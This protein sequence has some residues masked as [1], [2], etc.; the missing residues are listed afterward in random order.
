MM[1]RE[2]VTARIK[3]KGLISV[4]RLRGSKEAA[5]IVEA[6][7]AGGVDCVELTMTTPGALAALQDVTRQF[8]ERVVFGAGTVLDPETAHHAIAAGARFVVSPTLNLRLIEM[9]HRY[10]VVAIPGT[11]TP[12]E[13]L[14]AWE[15]GSD[16]IKV[17]PISPVG[18]G[19]L[20]AVLAPL[21]QLEIIPTGGVTLQ[22][23]VDYIRSGA[24][25]VGMTAALVDDATIEA[26]R[27]EVITQRAAKLVADIAAARAG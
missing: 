16:L 13:M 27:W 20:K 4:L 25:A 9:C 26:G 24:V 12:T 2:E 6:L 11:F 14:A 5:Q 1:A 8:G 22:T 15:A 7:G 18:P 23:A 17:F 21:P 10:G 19:Y 3:A